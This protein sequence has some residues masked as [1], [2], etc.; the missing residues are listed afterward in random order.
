MET[1]WLDSYLREADLGSLGA[2]Q[3][4]I[5]LV[6]LNV[7]EK[8][9]VVVL[10][11]T[12][13]CGPW[14]DDGVLTK[15]GDDG[16]RGKW[17]R[18]RTQRAYRGAIWMLCRRERY[19]RVVVWWPAGRM[20]GKQKVNNRKGVRFIAACIHHSSRRVHQSHGHQTTKTHKK[21]K[22]VARYRDRYTKVFGETSASIY[23]IRSDRRNRHV[24]V[25]IFKRSST[26]LPLCF[27]L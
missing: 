9:V 17:S 20:W 19:C 16:P 12:R 22:Q 21:Y 3:L 14:P 13:W 24:T 27:A 5:S 23:N 25:E 6:C 1:T 7:E 4:K 15:V 10:V 8:M 2:G 11:L 26:I 18:K